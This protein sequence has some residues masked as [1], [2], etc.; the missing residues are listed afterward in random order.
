MQEIFCSL[1]IYDDDIYE[2]NES[3]QVLLEPVEKEDEIVTLGL[4]KSV[5]ITIVDSDDS[6]SQFLF[7][8]LFKQKV[9]F[10]VLL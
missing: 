2:G 3:F 1:S 7:A 4:T 10:I 8:Y 9:I 6:R 5:Q